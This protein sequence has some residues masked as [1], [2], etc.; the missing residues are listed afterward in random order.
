MEITV[1]KGLKLK[2]PD[3]KPD[4][5]RNGGPK[6]VTASFSGNQGFGYGSLKHLKRTSTWEH[7]QKSGM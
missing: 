1:S 4:S 3:K 6:I 2:T 7:Q 5:D